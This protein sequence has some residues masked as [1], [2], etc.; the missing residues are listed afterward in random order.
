MR[1][2]RR[3][4]VSLSWDPTTTRT[5]TSREPSRAERSKVAS[6]GI[7]SGQGPRRGAPV[8]GLHEA[9]LGRPGAS[10]PKPSRTSH[11]RRS[12]EGRALAPKRSA[13][14]R[15]RAVTGAGRPDHAGPAGEGGEGAGRGGGEDDPGQPAAPLVGSGDRG[16]AGGRPC[17]PWS[18]PPR[19]RPPRRGPRG[20][21]GR[22][23]PGSRSRTAVDPGSDWPWPRRSTAMT[24]WWSARS[25]SWWTQRAELSMIPWSR[26]RAR[27][28]AT[29][30]DVDAA[31][32]VDVHEV[33]A[34]VVGEGQALGHHRLGRGRR[35]GDGPV[36]QRPARRPGDPGGTG[37][38]G[39]RP[40]PG[41]AC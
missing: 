19:R 39:Q 7:R 21:P 37:T 6:D 20:R 28:L 12:R 41:G 4:A 23:P 26:T 17:P 14:R 9:D 36:L 24:R 16:R 38:E 35:P 34:E 13:T 27:A 30:D 15:A 8:H 40:G 11:Q 29:F 5:G 22:R 18:G 33:M 2:A 3:G 1:R 32:V 31:A 10:A 25:R